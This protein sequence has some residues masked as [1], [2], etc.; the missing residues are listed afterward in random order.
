MKRKYVA[1][2][3]FVEAV[4]FIGANFDLIEAFVGGDAEFRNGRLVVATTN[5]PLYA[6]DGDV[7]IKGVDNRFYAVKPDFFNDYFNEV[8]P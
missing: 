6:D 1:R 8:Q 7:I 3:R 2:V 4:Q 5:G